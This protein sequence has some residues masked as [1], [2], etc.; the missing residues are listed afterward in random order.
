MEKVRVRL[1]IPVYSA[2]RGVSTVW[3]AATVSMKDKAAEDKY[4]V[5]CTHTVNEM[6]KTMSWCENVWNLSVICGSVNKIIN[7]QSVMK[8][9]VKWLLIF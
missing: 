7:E 4:A 6:N 1:C 9:Y 5:P 3:E 2:R 8:I